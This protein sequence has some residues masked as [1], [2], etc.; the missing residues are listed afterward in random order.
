[1]ITHEE[2]NKMEKKNSEEWIQ[3]VKAN[4]F[5]PEELALLYCYG[6]DW[7]GLLIDPEN[8]S[9]V[10]SAFL[11]C[12]MDPNRLVTDDPKPNKDRTKN[13]YLTP[14]IAATQYGFEN[15]GCAASLKLLF[16]HGGD[17][18]VITIFEEPGENGENYD[19]NVT[20]FYYWDFYSY[21]P[22]LDYGLLLCFAYGGR[23][24][25]EVEPFEMLIDAPPSVF[26]DYE[27][28][29]FEKGDGSMY[30]VE[31]ETGKRVAKWV[32]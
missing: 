20:D 21:G 28:Y 30:V 4:S 11:N 19:E 9:S 16:E 14:T 6:L 32:F 18:N 17:P 3:F 23:Y 7:S 24:V 1:M 27:K 13:F 2:I 8:I 26:K 22:N 25:N 10:T 12:G 29:W 15:P 5:S 31:K